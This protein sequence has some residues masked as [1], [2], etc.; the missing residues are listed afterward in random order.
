MENG[1]GG[2]MGD[3][4]FY[5]GKYGKSALVLIPRF[6]NIVCIG[7]YVGNQQFTVRNVTFNNA[8]SAGLY[9]NWHVYVLDPQLHFTHR[10]LG[11]GGG[12]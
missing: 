2:M 11:T 10:L 6:N 9:M 3:L 7:A 12:L 1:S 8:V 4:V 5:G